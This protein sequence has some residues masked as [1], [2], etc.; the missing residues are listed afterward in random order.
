MQFGRPH[1]YS[2]YHVYYTDRNDVMHYRTRERDHIHF[3][4]DDHKAKDFGNIGS[5][6]EFVARTKIKG[7]KILEKV[8]ITRSITLDEGEYGQQTNLRELPHG[9]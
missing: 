3:S 9:D 7:L 2:R 4:V 8:I 5:A 6:I 1:S